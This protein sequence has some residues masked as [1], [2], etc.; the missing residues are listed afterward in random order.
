MVEPEHPSDELVRKIF[1]ILMIFPHPII[2]WTT[3]VTLNAHKM[4]YTVTVLHVAREGMKRDPALVIE[5][6]MFQL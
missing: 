3:V 2:L 4:E 6:E 5:N 1:L